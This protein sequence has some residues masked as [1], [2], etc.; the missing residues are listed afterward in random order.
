M[1]VYYHY[2]YYITINNLFIIYLRFLYLFD[3]KDKPIQ[4]RL[5]GLVFMYRNYASWT[6]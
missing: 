5:Y 3:I 1:K 2:V 6:D 4:Q